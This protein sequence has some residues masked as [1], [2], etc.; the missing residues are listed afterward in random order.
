MDAFAILVDSI[1]FVGG[2][3]TS[4]VNMAV[5]R[6]QCSSRWELAQLCMWQLTVGYTL[7]EQESFD[8][9]EFTFL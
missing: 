8:T 3:S 9:E 4:A 6:W 1:F 7:R 5:P 2:S